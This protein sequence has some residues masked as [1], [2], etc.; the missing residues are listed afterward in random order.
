M[1]KKKNQKCQLF[2]KLIILIWYIFFLFYLSHKC[3]QTTLKFE[4]SVQMMA[5]FTQ[6]ECQPI[7]I[8]FAH[9]I[10][11][12]ILDIFF[13]CLLLQ[14]ALNYI[15]HFHRS[16]QFADSFSKIER[17]RDR[18]NKIYNSTQYI[19]SSVICLIHYNWKALSAD[20]VWKFGERGVNH[21][22]SCLLNV[23]QNYEVLETVIYNLDRCS[24]ID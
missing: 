1:K 7:T 11:A 21:V 8:F 22:Y 23:V 15:F 6:P 9:I 5:F 2:Y 13:M 24:C 20:V 3:T 16:S 4:I 17:F 10:H 19:S 18:L 14:S 12:I